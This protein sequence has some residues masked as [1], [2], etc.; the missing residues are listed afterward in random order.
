MPDHAGDEGA[1]VM[2]KRRKYLLLASSGGL[3][4]T[5]VGAQFVPSKAISESPVVELPRAVISHLPGMAG[6]MQAFDQQD[7]SGVMSQR[8]PGR[9][10][11]GK[12]MK[13]KGKN[14]IP[15]PKVLAE[16]TPAAPPPPLAAVAPA[17]TP[18]AALIPA[19]ATAFNPAI[20]LPIIPA[21]CVVVCD[22]DNGSPPPPPPPSPPPPSPPPPSPPP[23]SPPPPPPSPP[24]PPPPPPV[25]E[26]GTWM[27]MTVGFG[28]VGTA[29]RR[30]RRKDGT[31]EDIEVTQAADSTFKIEP[32]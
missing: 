6:V 11:E 28:L 27:M 17:A 31:A 10:V 16:S 9:R 20:L 21:A 24:P 5:G 3:L 2:G 7:V 12:L 8:S 4:A 30:R 18:L 1:K 22:S 19:A 25:P 29:L 13:T 23:P 15:A 32:L 14:L 26:P